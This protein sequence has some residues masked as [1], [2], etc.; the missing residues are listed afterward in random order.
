[1]WSGCWENPEA[2]WIT[3]AWQ[4]ISPKVIM[5]AFKNYLVSSAGD[6]SE[7]VVE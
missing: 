3:T 6:G 4:L 7:C 5:K 1:M 2:Q